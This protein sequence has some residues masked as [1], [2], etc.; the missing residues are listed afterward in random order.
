[1][2]VSMY[3]VM[4]ARVKITSAAQIHFPVDPSELAACRVLRMMM[5]ESEWYKQK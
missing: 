2:A 1:M 4:Y 3:A 5:L